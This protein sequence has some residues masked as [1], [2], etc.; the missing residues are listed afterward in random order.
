[1][2]RNMQPRSQIVSVAVAAVFAFVIA[3]LLVFVVP[4]ATRVSTVANYGVQTADTVRLVLRIAGFLL[5]AGGGFAAYF[6]GKWILSERREAA[7]QRH[8]EENPF[9]LPSKD[10]KDPEV[11]KRGLAWVSEQYPDVKEEISE[12]MVLQDSLRRNLDTIDEIFQANPGII[13]AGDTEFDFAKYEI[14]LQRTIDGTCKDLV[15]IIYQ[16]YATQSISIDDL[17]WFIAGVN[18]AHS[19]RLKL[20]NDL[21][22]MAARSVPMVDQASDHNAYAPQQLQELLAQLSE[23]PLRKDT[24]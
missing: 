20:A 4:G 17:K 12:T 22:I 8:V 13:T 15:K 23:N 3:A 1:M 24:L 14:L 2:D 7:A 5:A 9:V 11:I 16:A 10:E 19:T 6:A 21:A 18:E